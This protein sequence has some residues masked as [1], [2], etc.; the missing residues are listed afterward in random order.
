MATGEKRLALASTEIVAET[1]RCLE[2]PLPD[3]ETSV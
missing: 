1:A 2:V 3:A